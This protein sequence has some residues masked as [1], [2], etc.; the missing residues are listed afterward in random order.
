M[1]MIKRQ[2]LEHEST[3]SCASDQYSVS[4]YVYVAGSS[5]DEVKAMER[6]PVCE[7]DPEV[8]CTE[9]MGGSCSCLQHG[10]LQ[11]RAKQLFYGDDA[12]QPFMMDCKCNEC[13]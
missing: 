12:E 1:K 6:E 2:I 13:S 8:K 10:E 3:F 9:W 4:K 7:V 5:D 11:Q